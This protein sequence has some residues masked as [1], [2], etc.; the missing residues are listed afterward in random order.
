MLAKASPEASPPTERTRVSPSGPLLRGDRAP[1]ART[2]VDVLDATASRHPDAPAVDDG[3]RVWSYAEL[4]AEVGSR[5]RALARHG[6]RRGD[7]VGVRATSGRAD[8][9]LS[10]LAVLRAGAAY[11]PVDRDDPEER[12]ELVFG[13]AGVVAVVG[14]DGEIAPGLGVAA[15]R[16]PGGA[17]GPAAPAA[18]AAP[19]ATDDAW[20]I[21]TS[22]STGT[23]KGVTVTHRSAA[24]FVDAEARLFLQDA[25]LGPGDRVLA[26][27]SVAFDA[28]CEEMWLAWGHGA[29][30]VPADRA[31]VRTGLDLGPWVA[32]RGITVISTV[33]TLAGLL[34]AA[35]LARVRLLIFGGEAVP[36]ELAARLVGPGREV[37]NTY[38]PTEATVVA[39]AAVL[40]G[41]GPV[42]IGLP[43]D[44][45]DLAVVDEAGEPVPAGATG[46]LVIGG[47]GLGRYLD[48]GKDAEK[49]A[50]LPSLG[51]ARAYRSGD[52]VVADPD[53][54]LFVGRADDQVKVGGRRIE[55]GEI[56]SAL[57][58]APQV[59]AAAA[60]VRR[61]DAGNQMIVGYVVPADPGTF[62]GRALTA[63][64]REVLPAALVPLIGV[65][66]EIPTRTSG[67]VDRD[68]LPW[69]LAGTPAGAGTPGGTGDGAPADPAELGGPT[70]T[71]VAARWAAVLGVAPAASDED[72]F[73]LGGGSLTAAQVVSAVR[74]RYPSATVADLY[75]HPTVAELAGHLERAYGPAD[76]ARAGSGAPAGPVPTTPVGTQAFQ[77]VMLLLLR[78][79][80][81]LRWAAWTALAVAGAR[82]ATDV[83]LLAAGSAA[84][85]LAGAV[86][87][88]PW[89]AVLLVWLLLVTPVGRLGLAVLGARLLLR[90]VRPG[91]HPRGGS[92]HRRL[93]LAEQ[94]VTALGGL[95]IS[96]APLVGL[97]ARALGARMGRG[98]DLHTL[99]P[100]TGM[101]SVGDGAAVEP[102]VDLSGHW[103]EGDVLHVG[104]VT[105]GP[106]AT[107]G[108]RSVLLPGARVRRG[109]DVAA[110][111]A[112]VG[113]TGKDEYWEGSPATRRRSQ[114]RHPWPDARPPR[115]TRWLVLYGVGGVVLALLPV[116]ALAVGVAVLLGGPGPTG[117]STPFAELGAAAV[118]LPLAAL[119]AFAAYALGTLVLVRL[120][121]VRM[122]EGWHAVRSRVGWQAWCTERVMDSARTALFPLYSS[123]VTP[124]WLRLL[125][126]RMG[127]HVEASTVVGIPSMMEASDGAF[128]ADDTMVAPYQL[129]GGWMRVARAKVG[130]RAFLGNSGITA[131]GRSVPKNGLV[132]VLSAAPH[133][134][135][136]GSSW[137][138]S[139][140]VLLRRPAAD[141]ADEG[142]T[143]DPSRRLLWARGGVEVLRLLAV[144]ASAALSVLVV[145]AVLQAARA[146]GWTAAAV[147][148][149]PVLLV[150]GLAAALLTSAVKWLLVGRFRAGDHPLWSGFVW[151]NELADTFTEVVAA[152]WF[153]DHVLGTPL[154]T[155]WLRTMGAHIGRGVWC[156][157]Y[158]L[159]EGDLVT[160]GDGAAVGRG[161]VLQTHLFHDRVMSLDA[162]EVGPGATVGPHSVVLPATRL[163]PGAVAGP[164]SLVMRGEVLPAGSRW[165]GNP[166]S[167][168]PP[169]TTAPVD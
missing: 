34:P 91:D 159:P 133:K 49:Y 36:P 52:L 65:V 97:Y 128:L 88:V 166:V 107:V 95:T 83:G 62:D 80:S 140:P 55:L 17:S 118:R 93:W 76:G 1:S 51:W 165:H 143:F 101:L 23:P 117:P 152:P 126:A 78:V 2:L 138:G 11:V 130:R 89:V 29:C 84:G 13:E 116:A 125:G 134:A 57:L 105:V 66:G 25:P 90:G 121:S 100:V 153:A 74:E 147:L 114:V 67:K 28:S 123:V 112:V 58:D 5:A 145:T 30:L 124:G 15:P 44:G 21:F 81:G 38:G 87:A 120:L 68:A 142:L 149:G 77:Q 160:L 104:R 132:A 9:Y 146:W 110:G 6:V 139:P 144:V 154:L 4:S 150:A 16:R 102:E 75:A 42:R 158:W 50:P 79:V 137:I 41:V 46:E 141:D 131:P 31:L 86:P 73:D 99:P 157:T 69:P 164:A 14:D 56:D 60:A 27:L 18:P 92:V 169:A 37:W 48:A 8:L 35:D 22:G 96:A 64:L 33:P 156:E 155:G 63:H 108:A 53:G 7:R 54:L 113:S 12:A 39:C 122:T 135:R 119:C 20:I 127:K 43:L 61:T 94:L 106:G 136:K 148:A 59:S 167:P 162:V 111:S 163:A 3:A 109:T 151:R 129:G 168:W 161:T 70:A 72:F 45:W 115:G 82:W 40:D 71:W 98:V 47:V 19:R 24:A 32:E 26:G 10:I 103:L 85:R